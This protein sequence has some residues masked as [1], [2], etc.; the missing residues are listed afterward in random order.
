MKEGIRAHGQ[1]SSQV[2]A[3][4]SGRV[5]DDGQIPADLP[6]VDR[7]RK[8]IDGVGE[9]RCVC[10]IAAMDRQILW[11][12]AAWNRDP[13]LTLIRERSLSPRFRCRK[14]REGGEQDPFARK[15][16]RHAPCSRIGRVEWQQ[17]NA[18]G[19]I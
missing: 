12:A 14:R 10:E 8:K 13:G 2:G 11:I 16:S 7:R 9:H 3:D 15:M 5:H 1:V 17:P 6:S 4:A 18:T 19:T